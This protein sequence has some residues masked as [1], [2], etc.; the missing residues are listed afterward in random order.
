MIS[1]RASSFT[2]NIRLYRVLAT[3][4]YA[5][6]IQYRGSHLLHNFASAIFGYLYACI[7]IGLGRDHSLG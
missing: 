5:R 4:A 2:G 1:F 3:K 7:W 6:N